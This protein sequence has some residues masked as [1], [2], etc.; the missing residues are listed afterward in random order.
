MGKTWE[1]RLIL[2]VIV[3]RRNKRG[4]D[5]RAAN[6]LIN[7]EEGSTVVQGSDWNPLCEGREDELLFV[8]WLFSVFLATLPVCLL[9]F[10]E[11]NSL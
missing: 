9:P 8:I 1:A 5:L 4:N 2:I 6:P 7:L 3:L 10:L 11:C